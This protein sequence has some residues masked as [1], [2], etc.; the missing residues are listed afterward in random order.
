MS[1]AIPRVSSR[2]DP[3]HER[4]GPALDDEPVLGAPGVALVAEPLPGPDDHPLDL[5][6]VGVV[7]DGEA[8]P[9]PLVRLFPRRHLLIMPDARDGPVARGATT[10]VTAPAGLDRA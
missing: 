8:P 5:V 1:T 2:V 9:R 6:P 4:P 10:P 7:E 3:V